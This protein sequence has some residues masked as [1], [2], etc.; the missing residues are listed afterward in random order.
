MCRHP[1]SLL[2]HNSFALLLI[3]LNFLF[4]SPFLLPPAPKLLAIVSLI[5]LSKGRGIDLYDSGLGQSIG[6][7]KL[8]I[9]RVE[10]DDNDAHFAGDAFAAPREVAGVEA[11]GAVLLVAAAGADEVDT[12]GADAGV[13]G[14]AAFFEGSVNVVRDV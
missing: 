4:C 8:V 5:P 14:L 7:H 10:G 2:L 12:F 3:L 6:A 11:E 13:G 9:R 1:S